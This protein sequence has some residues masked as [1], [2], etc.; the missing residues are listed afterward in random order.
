M[1]KVLRENVKY[2]S[3]ILW[4][5]I[6]IFVLFVFVDFGGFLPGDTAPQSMAAR[7]GDETVTMADFQNQYRQTEER[8]RQLYGEQFS[9]DLARQMR[10][11]VELGR[12]R[13]WQACARDAPGDA[14]RRVV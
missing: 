10:R 4:V 12:F 1:L 2:L 9:P 13:R 8:L 5:V 11:A 6:G 3:W 14:G 7:V